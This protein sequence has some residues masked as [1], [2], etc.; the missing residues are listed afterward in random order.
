MSSIGWSISFTYRN[1]LRIFVEINSM[2]GW[3]QG[4]V[5]THSSFHAITSDSRLAVNDKHY[6]SSIMHIRDVRDKRRLM[7]KATDVVLF[8]PPQRK[9]ENQNWTIGKRTAIVQTMSLSFIYLETHN[10]LK[11]VILISALFIS[12]GG[13]IYASIRQRQTQE[14]MNNMLKELEILQQAEGN[15]LA[16][17]GR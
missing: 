8:G 15:L 3:Y 7:I 2:V 14:N 5:D 10:L 16:V 17:T 11:D 1:T 9:H 6:I 13:C 4:T 12:V